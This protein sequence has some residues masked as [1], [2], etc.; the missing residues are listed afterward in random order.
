M[1]GGIMQVVLYDEMVRAIDACHSVDQVK[2]IRDKARALEVYARQARNT[3]AE[4][5]AAD[6]RLRA[7]RHTGELL[8]DLARATPQTAR[9]IGTTGQIVSDHKTRFEGSEYSR[10]L[11][12]N[13]LSRQTAHRYEQLAE[14][15]RETFERA[16]A[17]PENRPTTNGILR[18]SRAEKVQP[19]NPQALR[20][21]GGVRDFERHRDIYADPADLFDLMTETMQD[22]MRRLV[23]LMVDFWTSFNKEIVQ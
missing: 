12:Q 18:E 14:V 8:R 22:D 7:E 13:G 3:D 17:D 4:R 11:E 16:L 20:I 5:K 6:V 9:S 21:W 15:P 10:T 23:P 19:I 1:Q 2:D